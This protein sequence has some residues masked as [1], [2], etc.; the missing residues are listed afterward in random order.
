MPDTAPAKP[1]LRAIK[2]RWE[3][4]TPGDWEW[5]KPSGFIDLSAV[6]ARTEHRTNDPLSPVRTHKTVIALDL[7]AADAEFMAK[8]HSD[9]PAL[10]ADIEDRRKLSEKQLLQ[11]TLVAGERDRLRARLDAALLANQDSDNPASFLRVRDTLTTDIGELVPTWP[12]MECGG[13]IKFRENPKLG[14]AVFQHLD[15]PDFPHFPV[16]APGDRKQRSAAPQI[17]PIE[18]EAQ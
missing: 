2:R 11:I 5:L 8:A 1:N 17:T 15:E 7:S 9:I 6:R 14:G 3:N 12:C 18:G 13:D 10:L 4:S 16:R